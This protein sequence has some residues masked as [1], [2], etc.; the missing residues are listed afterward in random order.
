MRPNIFKIHNSAMGGV[1]LFDMF[2]SLY[3]MDHRWIT[4]RRWYA[5]IFYWILA[6]SIINAWL[7]YRRDFD[8][9]QSTKPKRDKQKALVEFTM[10]LAI[11]LLTTA[12]VVRKRPG[13][14]LVSSAEVKSNTLK[15]PRRAP[16]LKMVS[17][18]TRFDNNNH[19]LIHRKDR[20]KCFH[21][22]EK[23]IVGS[24]KCGR[25]LCLTEDRNYFVEYYDAKL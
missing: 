13:R 21:Y 9:V 17:D 16:D 5:C 22:K 18:D 7:Q 24:N 11:A 4:S 19:W 25:E 3:R 2:Q 23:T 12:K 8:G 14:P 6:S 1:D 20:P 15:R 10:E